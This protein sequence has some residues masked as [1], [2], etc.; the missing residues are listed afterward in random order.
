[1]G[2]VALGLPPQEV[3][4]DTLSVN[5]SFILTSLALER[6]IGRYRTNL[7]MQ[8]EVG[9]RIQLGAHPTCTRVK[10]G[11]CKVV[12]E[13]IL[14]LAVGDL[15]VCVKPVISDATTKGMS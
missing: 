5:C 2:I 12:I 15:N 4:P 3:G 9:I 6:R 14:C 1:M 13:T 7:I 11:D 10:T 8:M